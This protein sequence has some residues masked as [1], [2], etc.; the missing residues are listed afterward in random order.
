[1]SMKSNA[2][3]SQSS[4]PS[5][6]VVFM[7][8]SERLCG[9]LDDIIAHDEA[10]PMLDYEG[11]LTFVFG[12]DAKDVKEND[13]F[14]YLLGYTVG[15]DVSARNLVGMEVTFNQMGH[16]KSFDTFGPMGPCIVSTKLIPDPQNLDLVTKVNGAVRQS[17]NTSDMIWKVKTLVAWVTK[18]R[19]IKKGTVFMTGTPSGVG[20]HSGGLLKDGDV[21]EV[22]ISEIGSISNKVVFV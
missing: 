8:P 13:A 7:T 9:P 5:K 17:T 10:Q 22:E 20:W 19:T 14:D 12:K 16:S 18:N 21:V 6:P 11:E 4:L 2:K 1:M 3:L 15:N